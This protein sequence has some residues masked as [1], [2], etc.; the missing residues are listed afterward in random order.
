MIYKKDNDNFI[1]SCECGCGEGIYFSIDKRLYEWSGHYF[2]AT[3]VSYGTNKDKTSIWY[4]LKETTLNI[5]D[6]LK[7]KKIY[8]RGICIS[9]DDINFLRAWLTKELDKAKKVKLI[10]ERE[11]FESIFNNNKVEYRNGEEIY[12]EFDK[13]IAGNIIGELGFYST[14]ENYNLKQSIKQILREFRR[15][16]TI[17]SDFVLSRVSFI[18]FCE[19]ILSII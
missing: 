19:Y 18:H 17:C 8:R 10:P 4:N 15:N 13:D 1:L 5:I 2:C 7:G 16:K 12:I 11:S 6:L 3:P 14:I 9:D